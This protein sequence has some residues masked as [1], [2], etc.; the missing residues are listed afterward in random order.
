MQQYTLAGMKRRVKPEPA[1]G[2][3]VGVHLHIGNQKAV[4]EDAAMAF[5][6]QQ[7]AQGRA[8]SVA[9]QH[10]LGVDPVLAFG[11]LHCHQNTIGARHQRR[12]LAV[13]AQIDQRQLQR[14][15]D[16]IGLGVVLLQVD[17]G[18]A[19]MAVLGQQVKLVQRLVLGKYLAQIPGHA[20]VHHGL[21]HAQSIPDLQRTLGKADGAR[22]CGQLAV[23]IEHHHRLAAL[24]QIDG[25]RQAHGAGTDDDNGVLHRFCRILIRMA[26]IGNL[27]GL[28]VGA[29]AAQGLKG[30]GC[31]GHG[32]HQG[33]R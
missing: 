33:K 26:H 23:V 9:G 7:A 22:A 10:P 20:L 19:F 30:Y 27:N 25:Q 8:R 6:T 16:Q 29:A 15:L 24:G 31:V 18:R 28:N 2:G 21:A 12:D 17:E 4:A 13:P 3:E 5:L 32:V 11:R 1:L 14:A